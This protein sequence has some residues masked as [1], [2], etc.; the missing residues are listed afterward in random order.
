MSLIAI[1]MPF[2]E[3]LSV[4]IDLV[5]E[6]VIS[7]MQNKFQQVNVNADAFELLLQ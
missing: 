2:F 5:R 1:N 7:N 4:I 6:L 3:A